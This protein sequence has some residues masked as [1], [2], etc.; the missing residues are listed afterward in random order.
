MKLIWI[1]QTKHIEFCL[2]ERSIFVCMLY[3]APCLHVFRLFL[4]FCLFACVSIPA[5]V[6]WSACN[7]SVETHSFRSIRI[8]S[9]GKDDES[10]SLR[11]LW[12]AWEGAVTA[13]LISLFF[14]CLLSN[15]HSFFSVSQ[16]FPFPLFVSELC[17]CQCFLLSPCSPLSVWML[18]RA[19]QNW[20]FFAVLKEI[21]VDVL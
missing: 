9:V 14:S 4:S 16:D 12:L 17:L 6:T 18:K 19:Y 13:A 15:Y 5:Q 11:Y 3:A 2:S 21:N 1:R 7:G 20:I 8:L 10:L